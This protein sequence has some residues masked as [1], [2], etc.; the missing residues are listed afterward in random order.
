VPGASAIGFD[1][2]D[3]GSGVDPAALH[4]TVDGSDVTAWGTYAG[5][6]YT[7]APGTLAAGVHTVAVS[8]ADRAG[9]VA[10]PVMWQFAVADPATLDLTA[11]GATSLTAGGRA[12]IRFVARSNGAALVGTHV[13][14]SSR[15][16]GGRGLHTIRTLTTGPTGIVTLAVAPLRNTTYRAVLEAAPAV[17][18]T[19]SVAV[20][21]RV[22]LAADRLRIARGGVVRLTGRV[23]PGRPGARV[24][25]QLLSGGGWRTVAQPRLGGASRFAKTVIAAIPGRYV[26]R[27]V[28]PA[29]AANAAG[30]SATVTV[31]V[32]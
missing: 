10:G 22:A 9:N 1:V 32:R 5:G 17:A 29:T 31:R 3:S 23:L 21:Q 12:V 2:S 16:A 24:R 11:G 28:A 13:V 14:I 8:A 30:R 19:R 25:V 27:V 6:R 18:A 4:V 20:H 26:L 7:Y 15:P